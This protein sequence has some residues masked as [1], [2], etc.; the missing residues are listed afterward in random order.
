MQTTEKRVFSTKQFAAGNSQ[1][2]RIPAPIAFPPGTELT[3]IRTGNIIIVEPRKKTMED[4]PI[5]FAKLGEKM[6][7]F[8][9]PEFED[10]ERDW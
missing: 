2:V 6:A 9:R 5:L 4:I 10:V 1:A 8:K 3:V 7:D